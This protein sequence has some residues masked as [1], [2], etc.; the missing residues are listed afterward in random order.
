[1]DE[2]DGKSAE[3]GDED[4]ES[5]WKPLGEPSGESMV[6]EGQEEPKGDEGGEKVKSDRAG[7][8]SAAWEDGWYESV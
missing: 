7:A 8:G 5:E 3:V 6:A 2:R 4:G 1:M